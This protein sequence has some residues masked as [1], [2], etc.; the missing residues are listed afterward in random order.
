VEHLQHFGLGDEP[1]ANQPSL[2]LWCETPTHGDAVRRL[3][4][5]AQQGKGLVLLVGAPG[6]GKTLLLRRVLD[7]LP[8]ERFEAGVLV[9]MPGDGGPVGLLDRVARQVGVEDAP[10]ERRALL[11][12]VYRRLVELREEGRHTVVLVDGAD[13][14]A[15]DAGLADLRSLLELE[16][17]ERGVLTLVLAGTAALERMLG[18]D[19]GLAQRVEIKVHLAPLDDAAARA[20]VA[21]RLSAVGGSAALFDDAALGALVRASGG[22]PRVLNTLADNA[23]FE[24]HVAKRKSV[25]HADVARAAADLGLSIDGTGGAGAA[26]REQAAARAGAA[27]RPASAPDLTENLR[28]LPSRPAPTANR[29][30]AAAAAGAVGEPDGLAEIA[31]DA[32]AAL[33]GA[34]SLADVFDAPGEVGEAE[35]AIAQPVF[36][37]TEPEIAPV[38]DAGTSWPGGATNAGGP[39]KEDEIEELFDQLLDEPR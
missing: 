24:A 27:G 37:T 17:E 2:A 8:E 1:F 6:T 16:H 3:L 35:G 36:E 15:K 9:I 29:V 20:Y 39:P 11:G 7:E 38:F 4:R 31:L 26:G 19:P 34:E 32:D 23:L 5:G 25:G 28:P 12:A 13:L 33:D 21:H 22:V 10:S 18:G 14:L 30:A